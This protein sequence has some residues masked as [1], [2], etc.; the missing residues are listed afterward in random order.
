MFY[1][2]IMGVCEKSSASFIIVFVVVFYVKVCF[3]HYF[4]WVT[5]FTIKS[6][7]T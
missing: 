1:H 5:Y 3:T 2:F 4:L 6:K 7:I